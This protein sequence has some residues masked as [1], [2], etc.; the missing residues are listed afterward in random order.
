M[1][2]LN[3][4]QSHYVPLE[5]PAF[6]MEG[7]STYKKFIKVYEGKPNELIQDEIHVL[8]PFGKETGIPK[9][10]CAAS[11]FN[12][13]LI[14][15]AVTIERQ[16]YFN[17]LC[18]YNEL[19]VTELD[20]LNG[21]E[22]IEDEEDELMTDDEIKFMRD[23]DKADDYNDEQKIKEFEKQNFASLTKEPI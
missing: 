6:F 12:P 15:N 17:R 10:F 13:S 11:K 18:D 14:E 20:S 2:T 22:S 7:D 4:N 16:E 21:H 9:L 5:I 23:C 3:R 8:Y 19:I 1:V